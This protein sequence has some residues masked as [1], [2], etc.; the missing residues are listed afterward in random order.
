MLGS[1]SVTSGAVGVL[2]SLQLDFF[3][4]QGKTRRRNQ[5]MC[6]DGA[7]RTGKVTQ[8]LA[9]GASGGEAHSAWSGEVWGFGT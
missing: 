1:W 9:C 2:G 4:P 3:L 6:M 5:P 7:S 8:P